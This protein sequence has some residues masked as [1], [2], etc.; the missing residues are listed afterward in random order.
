MQADGTTQLLSLVWALEATKQIPRATVRERLA[1]ALG[2]SV[3]QW[4]QQVAR[5]GWSLTHDQVV[6]LTRTWNE[7]TGWGQ[8]T[9]CMLD[10]GTWL[11]P[12]YEVW[13][14]TPKMVL[15]ANLDHLF[16]QKG[17]GAKAWLA[18]ALELPPTT[19]AKWAN[20]QR[21]GDRVR[22]PPRTKHDNLKAAFGLPANTNLHEAPLFLGREAVQDEYLRRD[23]TSLLAKL[24]GKALKRE[25]QR[26]QAR[27]E[28][29]DADD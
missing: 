4:D 15:A 7:T 14:R 18:K 13:L 29:Y 16:R 20:W 27:V 23:A 1:A 17:R 3:E 19:V 11:A 2:W 28:V 12:V 26:L 21:D 24:S 22:C 8:M 6:V 5:S 10:E 9:G 25:V